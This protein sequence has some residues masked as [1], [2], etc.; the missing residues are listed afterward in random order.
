MSKVKITK[1]MH[2]F[3]PIV[4]SDILFII[5]APLIWI[6]PL[7]A[8]ASLLELLSVQCLVHVRS[9]RDQEFIGSG[10]IGV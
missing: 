4:S 5:S 1:V 8:Y 9:S 10:Q 6:S 3:A 2:I 7:C